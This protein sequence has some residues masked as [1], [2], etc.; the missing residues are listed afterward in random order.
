MYLFLIVLFLFTYSE[1]SH[2]VPPKQI[3]RVA[4]DE[5]EVALRYGLDKSLFVAI[6]RV[7]SGLDHTA[8]NPATMDYGIGQINYK[9]AE[10]FGISIPRLLEDR[11]YS[12]EMSAMVLADFKRMFAHKEPDTWFARYNCGTGAREGKRA[13]NCDVYMDRVLAVLWDHE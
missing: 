5:F 9:T 10:A 11:A 8:I 4:D 7:E 2:E 6:L 12:I 3:E 13:Y 1:T